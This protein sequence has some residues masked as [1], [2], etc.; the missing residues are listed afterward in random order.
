MS[1]IS[2]AKNNL[3]TPGAYMANSSVREAD[4][5]ARIPKTGE[6][7]AEYARR[8]KNAGAMDF[9][10]LLLLTNL[11]F[12]DHPEILE[13]YQ[14]A[15]QYILVDE[16]QDTNFS[17]YMIVKKLAEP[18]QNICVVGDDAQSIYAFR[19]ARIENILNFRIQLKLTQWQRLTC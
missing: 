14:Q 4:K 11:L 16:Y 9:D 5:M 1:R 15:F 13:K 3:V 2:A 10:D 19:G 17:Q 7:Y 8:C 12:R 6:I 18:H